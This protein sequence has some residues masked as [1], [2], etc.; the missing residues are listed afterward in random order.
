MRVLYRPTLVHIYNRDKA[1]RKYTY[2]S[3]YGIF[4]SALT[5]DAGC[6]NYLCAMIC[7]LANAHAFAF[8][9]GPLQYVTRGQINAAVITALSMAPV[10]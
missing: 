8:S 5:G 3:L 4:L 7:V 9:A 10:H 6:T 2:H 1:L